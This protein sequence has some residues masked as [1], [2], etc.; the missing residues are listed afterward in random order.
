MSSK[1]AQAKLMEFIAHEHPEVFV[2]SVHPGVVETK[3]FKEAELM[4]S[5]LPRDKGRFF[6]GLGVLVASC[7]VL[8]SLDLFSPPLYFLLLPLIL[9]SLSNH[10]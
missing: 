2:C 10:N 6:W 8:F 1:I 3:M 4:G 7:S 9:L 5:S